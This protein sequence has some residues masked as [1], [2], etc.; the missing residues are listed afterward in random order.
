MR[1]GIQRAQDRGLQ[2]F[3]RTLSRAQLAAA[4]LQADPSA[5]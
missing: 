3:H 1:E 4:G 2:V 5:S